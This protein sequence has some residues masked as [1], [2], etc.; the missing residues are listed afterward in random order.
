MP[1][2]SL[3]LMCIV[4]STTH[5]VSQVKSEKI[6]EQII[7]KISREKPSENLRPLLHNSLLFA[8]ES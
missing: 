5:I 7:L 3:I 8:T 6:E 2:Y 1:Q 4:K